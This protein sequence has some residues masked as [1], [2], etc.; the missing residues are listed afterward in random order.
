MN[1]TE[2]DARWGAK[3]KNKKCAEY[4]VHITCDED[5][6]FVSGLEVLRGNSYEAKLK[7]V[8][9]LVDWEIDSIN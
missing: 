3:S 2:P 5:I 6:G 9:K 8:A 7:E 1:Y 4:K